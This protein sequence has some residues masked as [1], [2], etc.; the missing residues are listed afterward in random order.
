M[1]VTAQG[2]QITRTVEAGQVSVCLADVIN[3]NGD[4]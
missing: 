1:S 3:D 2:T 4:E